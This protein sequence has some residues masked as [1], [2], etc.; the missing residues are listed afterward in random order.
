MKKILLVTDAWYPQVNGVVRVFATL[1]PL[2]EA[3]GFTVTLVEPSQFRSV[4]MPFYRE[5]AWSLFPKRTVGRMIA[6]EAPEYVHI[7][8]EGPLGLAA[9]SV[10]IARGIPFTTSYHTHFQLHLEARIGTALTG[11]A[12]AFLR[13]FHKPASATMVVTEHLRETLQAHGFAHV[14][15]WPLGVDTNLF[16]RVERPSSELQKPVFVYMGRLSPEKSVEEFLSLSLPGSKLVIGDGPQR[17]SLEQTYGKTAHFVGYKKGQEL[18]ELLSAADVMVFPSRT[19][20]FGLVIVEALACGVPVAAH[21]V[22]GPNDILTDGVDG[23]L[24]EDLA[25]AAMR[26]LALR[27]EDCRATALRY[28]W[29]RSA[30]VFTNLLS[31]ISHNRDRMKVHE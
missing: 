20:T 24:D 30:Q 23:Y 19:E 15:V 2:L 25:D 14:S 22:M 10:C 4:P 6:K 5:I 17:A 13:W 28:S 16:T 18:V 8:T 7:A 21:D 26:C 27:P 31:P 1:M 12:Y 11:A 3:R 9:R 29:E